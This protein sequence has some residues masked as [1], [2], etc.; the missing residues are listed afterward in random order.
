VLANLLDAKHISRVDL[1]GHSW[2]ASIALAFA[3]RHP[4]RLHKLVIVSGW[5]FDEQ[6]LPL[7]RW[8][9]ARGVGEVLYS[10]FYRQQIG[11]RLYLNFYD[12]TR[13]TEEQ[14]EA[15]ERMMARPG[16]VATALA[17]ARGMRFDE[18]RYPNIDADTLVI[19]GRN[20]RVARLQF[21]EK[22]AGELPHARM[23]TI[24]RCGHLPMLECRVPFLRAALDFL[25]A[26]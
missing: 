3:L 25:G 1:I 21:G 23:V 20:D 4:D 9:R 18:E 15:V 26:P 13:V 19:W 16:S 24:D 5:M 10:G 6:L 11:E 2:G 14:V 7:M 12:P 22:L 8:A 17:A